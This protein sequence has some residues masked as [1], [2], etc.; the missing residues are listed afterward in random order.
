[1]S[2]SFTDDQEELRRYVRQWLDQ[3]APLD[4]VRR[5]MESEPGYE[6]GQWKEL[7]DLGWLGMAIPTEWGG[8]GYGFGE[9]AV[10]GEEMGRTLYPSPF[11]PTV[12]MAAPLVAALGT[13]EQ[14]AELLTGIADASITAS[15]ALADGEPEASR[16]DSPTTATEDGAGGWS[17]SG[18][19]SYVVNG[20]T[21]DWLLV[22]AESP[23]GQEVFLV[24]QGVPGVSVEPLDVMDLTRP[25][26][27]VHLDSAPATR[28]GDGSGDVSAALEEIDNRA[29]AFLAMEEVGGAQAC[30]DMS[31]AYAKSR[32]QFGR[33]IGSFQAIKHMCAD[34]LV[35]VESAKSAAYHLAGV[36]GQDPEETALAAALA[37]SFCSEAYFRC[38]ADTIQVHGG[39]GFTWEHDAH[40]Y[41][42][43]AKSSELMFGGPAEHRRRLAD[44][45]GIA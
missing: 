22:T 16:P 45:L 41:L 40:L 36:V 1:M 18:V 44:G 7:G 17:L 42:K 33:P 38:A 34:M 43:R 2:V 30:L 23:A 10:M 32:Y 12:V 3:R 39:I 35:A 14:R 25:Q 11:L 19:K 6:P 37:K 27:T 5:I 28:L 24:E 26:A 31:V 29:V 9:L 21:A 15:V 13:E 20:A 8:S 4:E